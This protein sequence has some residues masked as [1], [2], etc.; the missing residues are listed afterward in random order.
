MK[1][2]YWFYERKEGESEPV[3][4]TLRSLMTPDPI[5]LFPD[6]LVRDA[7][8]LMAKNRFHH[9]PVVT[10]DNI[11]AGIVSAKDI[12]EKVTHGHGLNPEEQ[13]HATLDTLL[14]LSAVMSSKVHTLQADAPVAAAVELFL[15]HDIHCVPIVEKNGALVGIVTETD[16]MHLL[17]HMVS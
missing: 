11:L 12:L 5:T 4:L 1:G 13:Y 9:L 2:Q 16:M 8:A 17:K 3:P 10:P 15:I 7:M 6:Q 14:P